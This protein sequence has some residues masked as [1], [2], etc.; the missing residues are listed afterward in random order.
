MNR[1]ILAPFMALAPLSLSIYRQA[2]LLHKYNFFIPQ[3][4]KLIVNFERNSGYLVINSVEL[5]LIDSLYVTLNFNS[6]KK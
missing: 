2:E 6:H 4:A 5:L 1:A 3:P